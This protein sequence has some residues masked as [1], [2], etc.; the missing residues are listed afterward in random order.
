MITRHAAV[1]PAAVLLVTSFALVSL[2][3]HRR[4]SSASTSSTTP[5]V[6]EQAVGF[7]FDLDGTL[8]DFEGVAHDA[9]QVP[10]KRFGKSVDWKLHASISGKPVKTWAKEV[11]DTIGV[12]E[13]TPEEYGHQWH[14][15][16]LSSFPTMQLM[17]GALDL[18]RRCRQRYP[19]AKL[20]LATSSMRD[21]YEAKIVYHPELRSYFDAIVTGDEV[22]RGKPNPDIFLEAA[23][24]IGID[25]RKCVIFEDSLSG[26]LGAKNAASLVVAIPD[27]RMDF[28]HDKFGFADYRLKS[29]TE[30][31]DTMLDTIHGVLQRRH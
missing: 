31:D 8:I 27:H 6:S 17:P 2:A 24:R 22:E 10:L 30:L 23:R 12:T 4:R 21:N 7:I 11:L 20:A 13:L 1:T 18:V 28:I 26:A 29:L 19:R 16:T 25:P 14:E 15:A 9:L 5:V 3:R